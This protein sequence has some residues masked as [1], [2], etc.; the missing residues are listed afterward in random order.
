MNRTPV[1][2]STPRE[3]LSVVV[4]PQH[5]KRTLCVAVVVGTAFFAMNQ[6]G[7]ILHG[8][9]TALV[10]LKAGLTYLTPLVVS[11]VGVVTAT[12]R[13]ATATTESTARSMVKPRPPNQPGVRHRRFRDRRRIGV[14]HRHDR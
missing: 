3:L 4:A 1:T 7:V 5:L 8:G 14:R 9:G 12:R 2:W 10:W 11:N 6:L 13:A